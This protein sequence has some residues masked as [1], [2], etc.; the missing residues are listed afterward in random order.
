MRS[1][2]RSAAVA[3]VTICTFALLCNCA[4]S[5]P[6]VSLAPPAPPPAAR[7]YTSQLKKW[8]RHGDIRADFDNTIGIDATFHSPEFQEAYAAK[9]AE[10]YKLDPPEAAR[11]KAQ[12]LAAIADHYEFYVE[13]SAHTYALN[14]LGSSKTIWRV[15]LRDD[16]G[17][18]VVASEIAAAREQRELLM[19][20]YPYAGPWGRGWR[21]RFPRV[22]G[23]QSPLVG[24]N[25]K[26][27]VLR[28]AGPPGS[29][30]LVWR[31]K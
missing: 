6:Q 8:T 18:E 29:V 17:R 19:A 24:E 1:R 2:T 14:D 21:V 5:T 26:S 28:I 13:T 4:A 16:G 20:F 23:D 25:A 27:M 12:L 10:V 15:S 31:L 3:V 7:D 9:W 22:L 11:V 30:D